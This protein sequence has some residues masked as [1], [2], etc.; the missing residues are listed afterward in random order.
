MSTFR[1]STAA[2]DPVC[3][4][5]GISNVE[6]NK[7]CSNCGQYLAADIASVMEAL[8]TERFATILD[9]KV[10]ER[11]RDIIRSSLKDRDY[12]E[13]QTVANILTRLA[14]V[15]KTLSIYV[16]I[17][18]ALLGVTFAWWGINGVSDV[19][20]K[21]K[22]AKKLSTSLENT[23]KGANATLSSA[24]TT[25]ANL[26]FA[27]R[28]LQRKIAVAEAGAAGLKGKIQ[29]LEQ[30]IAQVKQRAQEQSKIAAS[31]IQA[32]ENSVAKATDS[33]VAQDAGSAKVS[34]PQQAVNYT[35]L[36]TALLATIRRDAPL[37]A[38]TI[39]WL[40]PHPDNNIDERAALSGGGAHV[41]I[42]KSIPEAKALLV[43]NSEINLIISNFGRS[44]HPMP[45]YAFLD[46]V[47]TL[48][49]RPPYIFYTDA[50][51]QERTKQAIKAGAYG[52]TNSPAQ[53]FSLV[54]RALTGSSPS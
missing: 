19:T 17:P 7:Y 22:A 16:V 47:K 37:R 5:C 38:A 41:L 51:T 12:L 40:D 29:D 44:D 48:P 54:T 50:A 4:R 13:N 34:P 11:V 14:T 1:T 18:L 26:Q 24:K 6:S 33:S 25:L 20:A 43:S 28:D 46:Y 9:S 15:G 52:E 45:G 8:T 35:N 21:V 2:G 3:A 36:Q 23:V 32:T 10:D 30:E 42:A 39:L 49:K 31:L 27:E 53:L